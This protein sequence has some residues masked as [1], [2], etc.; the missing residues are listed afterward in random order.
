MDVI[1]EPGRLREAFSKTEGEATSA[2]RA[3]LDELA[4][5]QEASFR[6]ALHS[7]HMQVAVRERPTRGIDK[8]SGGRE[9][10]ELVS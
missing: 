4:R 2:E 9:L 7:R 5:A 10:D 6:E 1:A 8:L 3:A